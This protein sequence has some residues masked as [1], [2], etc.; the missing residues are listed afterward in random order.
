MHFLGSD[1][2]DE[3]SGGTTADATN[4]IEARAREVH[5]SEEDLARASGR[6]A[7][8]TT[9][10]MSPSAMELMNLV[11]EVEVTLRHL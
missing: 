3:S 5:Y 7:L 8:M 9:D 4:T 11:L 6:W 1:A 2:E 10:H